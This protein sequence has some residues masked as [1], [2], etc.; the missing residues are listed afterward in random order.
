VSRASIQTFLCGHEGCTERA[1]Y[2]YYDR[3]EARRQWERYG[4]GKYRCVRHSQP[5]EVLSEANAKLT[6]D[7]VNEERNG[8]LYFGYSGFAHGPGFKAFSADFPAGTVLRVTAEIILPNT[9]T[10]SDGTGY[11]TVST[12]R[13]AE[14]ASGTNPSNVEKQA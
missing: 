10:P 9:L 11:D 3:A 14:D 13:T 6:R 4:N 5:D 2:E 8:H 1:R 12:L 7:L